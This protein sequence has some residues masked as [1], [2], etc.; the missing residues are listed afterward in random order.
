M[1]DNSSRWKLR[2]ALRARAFEFASQILTQ[3]FAVQWSKAIGTKG[4]PADDAW[5]GMD[6]QGSEMCL[7]AYQRPQSQSLNRLTDKVQDITI[8]LQTAAS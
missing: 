1:Q 7:R 2:N 6:M 4:I 3:E 8:D 5:P